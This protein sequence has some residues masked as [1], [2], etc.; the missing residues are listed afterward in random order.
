[1]ARWSS[2]IKRKK[3]KDSTITA[4]YNNG[5][6]SGS[7]KWHGGVDLDVN[8]GTKIY[9]PCGGKIVIKKALNYSYGHYY[10]IEGKYNNKTYR[11]W[12]CHMSTLNPNL[13]VGDTIKQGQYLGKSG[14][15][16]NSTGPHLHVEI[17][18]GPNFTYGS[19][20][21]TINPVHIINFSAIGGKS[22]GE[23][24]VS[25]SEFSDID[26]STPSFTDKNIKAATHKVTIYSANGKGHF[27]N[28]KGYSTIPEYYPGKKYG[29]TVENNETFKYL[30]KVKGKKLYYILINKGGSDNRHCFVPTNKCGGKVKVNTK[31]KKTFTWGEAVLSNDYIPNSTDIPNSDVDTSIWANLVNGVARAIG[32]QAKSEGQNYSQTYYMT[33]NINDKDYKN[34]VDCSGFVSACISVLMNKP[35]YINYSTMNLIKKGDQKMRKAGF[36]A[37]KFPGWDKLR[38]GDILV[39]IDHTEIFSRKKGNTYYGW[40]HGTTNGIR[41]AGETPI[42]KRNFKIIW[43]RIK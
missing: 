41:A 43:R 32:K 25:D 40:N 14:S 33:T 22:I 18:K 3:Y 28:L 9:S 8:T 16:G 4:K 37:Y 29:M 39:D 15:T 1:M 24:N 19:S 23:D 10:C 35:G 20:K 38:K 5:R 11:V 27:K 31:K 12:L 7:G 36:K 42:S 26:I 34:R 2:P 6:Y 13:Q 30:G 17:R 21:D